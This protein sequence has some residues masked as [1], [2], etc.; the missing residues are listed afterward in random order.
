MEAAVAAVPILVKIVLA[1]VTASAD[2]GR[3]RYFGIS[4]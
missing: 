3:S 4:I 1:A 2:A